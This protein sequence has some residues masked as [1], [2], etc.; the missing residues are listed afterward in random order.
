[1]RALLFGSQKIS[2]R[3]T[4]SSSTKSISADLRSGARQRF[5]W[6]P[7]V[8]RPHAWR[9]LALAVLVDLHL[10]DLGH[11]ERGGPGVPDARHDPVDA[12]VRDIAAALLIRH[13]VSAVGWLTP[14]SASPLCVIVDQREDGGGERMS[15]G[16]GCD[17]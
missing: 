17:K 16:L 9:G 15:W 6:L 11:L 14:C 7:A 12:G 4:S 10:A 8:V 1:V 2:T 5:C 3:F 13:V